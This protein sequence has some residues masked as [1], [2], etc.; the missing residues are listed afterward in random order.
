ME[1]PRSPRLPQ[2]ALVEESL[3]HFVSSATWG[4]PS[5]IRVEAMSCSDPAPML[6]WSSE[7]EV[8]EVH[9]GPGLLQDFLKLKNAKDEA[10]LCYA[11]RWGPLWMCGHVLPYAHEDTCWVDHKIGYSN[12]DSSQRIVRWREPIAGW[13]TVS[14]DA[15]AAV[16]IARQ[17][18]NGQFGRRDDWESMHYLPAVMLQLLYL[19]FT[20][21]DDDEAA[22]IDPRPVDGEESED[23]FE[24]LT[25]RQRLLVEQVM[26]SRLYDSVEFQRHVLS[27]VLNYWLTV[28][29]VRPRLRWS[30]RKP[31]IQ[32]GGQGLFSAL[33]VQLLFECARTDGLAVCTSCGTPFLP[34]ARRPRR[35]HNAY[36]SDCG[37][38][39]A[40]RDAAAR[41][42]QSEKYQKTYRAWLQKRRRSP[43]SSS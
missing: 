26:M 16:R 20:V 33:A 29:S 24:L 3:D 1:P 10:I 11:R 18:H 19:R 42:R 31:D 13:R 41:Y 6:V 5:T 32:L 38:K 14:R 4:V 36:C 8:L 35:D 37:L 22:D 7:T 21:A 15:G 34:A 25:P 9:A 43:S 40:Q 30:G 23:E 28:A 27:E 17:L 12:G 2:R 39:A